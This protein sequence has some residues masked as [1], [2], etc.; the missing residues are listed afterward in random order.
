V[1][2]AARAQFSLVACVLRLPHRIGFALVVIL[3][4][5]AAILAFIAQSWERDRVSAWLFV[6]YAT[7]VAYASVLNGAILVLN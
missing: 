2:G 4:L 5:L 3:L 7:W 6:P 1:V